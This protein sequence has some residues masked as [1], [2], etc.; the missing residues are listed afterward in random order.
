MKAQRG[1]G[2]VRKVV[3]AQGE[4]CGLHVS[5]GILARGRTP[6]AK[7]RLTYGGRGS[8]STPGLWL[9]RHKRLQALLD[10]FGSRQEAATWNAVRKTWM[11]LFPRR[12][13]F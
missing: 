3:M 9:P 1:V 6:M 10:F 11:I 5:Q 2:C 8:E 12:N 4:V 13:I 7:E